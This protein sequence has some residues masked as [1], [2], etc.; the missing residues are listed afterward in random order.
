VDPYT[1]LTREWNMSIWV[2]KNARLQE[3]SFHETLGLVSGF[4]A[5]RLVKL[6]GPECMANTQIDF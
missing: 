4:Q 1:R 6:T 5:S 3:V 2:N